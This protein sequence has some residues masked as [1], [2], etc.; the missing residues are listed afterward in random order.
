MGRLEVQGS[1]SNGSA[2]ERISTTVFKIYIKKK[3]TKKE[4]IK[5]D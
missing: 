3:K 1:S 5:I 2:L 4:E